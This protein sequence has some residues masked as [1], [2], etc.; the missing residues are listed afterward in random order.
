MPGREGIAAAFPAA[1][2]RRLQD[3][4]Q[5]MTAVHA[6]DP[7]LPDLVDDPA[8]LSTLRSYQVLGT[9][10]EPAFDGLARMARDICGA[11]VA[12]VS[13]VDTTRQWFKAV[14]GLEISQTPIDTSICA[15]TLQGDAFLEVPDTLADPRFAGMSVVTELGARFYAGAPLR[16]HDGHGLGAL[17]VLDTVP[18][19]LDPTQRQALTALAT[20][21]M[22]LLDMR[23]TLVRAERALKAQRRIMAV[24]GHDLGNPLM[25]IE[26]ALYMLASHPF[27]SDDDRRQLADARSAQ[28]DVGRTLHRLAQAS[29]LEDDVPDVG[30]VA[31]GE[32]FA[33]LEARW[34]CLAQAS[35]HAL[36]FAP[37]DAVLQTNAGLLGDLLDNLV[38]NA[39]KHADPGPV[40]IAA[41]PLARG[42]WIAVSDH[43][44]GIALAHR[45]RI[46]DALA[47]FG[48][49][50]SG[51]GLGLSI[52]Q[53]SAEALGADLSVHASDAGGA[54]FLLRLPLRHPSFAG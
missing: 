6:C 41:G 19:R 29:L 50:R 14:D 4:R 51:L 25:R 46:F 23:R 7:P 34:S 54:R 24:A 47:Q 11:P 1:G 36:V 33:A 21:A 26:L 8:R 16:S 31:I 10:P 45:Q 32:A 15:Y 37:I 28:A 52:A 13:L 9:P 22:A 2:G 3:D 44:P 5:T 38:G 18:R 20:Q 53:R 17:C 40:H 27:L 35:G 49:D 43:G 48:P 12:L 30:A 39:L 42:V